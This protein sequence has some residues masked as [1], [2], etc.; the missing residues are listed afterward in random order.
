MTEKTID[1]K[2][3]VLYIYD[4]KDVKANLCLDE[5][6]LFEADDPKPLIK[7]INYFLNYLSPLTEQ[8]LE[9]ALDLL[10]KTFV[11]RMM[12]YTTQESLPETSANIADALT[13]YHAKYERVHDKGRYAQIKI[14]FDKP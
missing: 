6:C 14:V 4:N 5:G 1:L 2:K 12:A 8:P 3:L 9:I 10:E 11:L 7:V 13:A